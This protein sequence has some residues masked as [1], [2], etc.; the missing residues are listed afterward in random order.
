MIIGGGATGVE[1]AAELRE[2]SGVYASYG[3]EHLEALR[4]VHITLLEGAPRILA[5][6]AGTGVGRRAGAAGAARHPR[7]HRLQGDRD[8]AGQGAATPAATPIRPT[9]ACGRPASARPNSCPRWAC[10]PRATASSRSTAGCASRASSNIYALGD[11]AACVD[12]DGKPVPPRAQA[13]HQQADFLRQTF[14]LQAAGKPPAAAR[15]TPTPITVRW[16]RS[17]APLRWAA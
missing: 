2:A 14:L 11:C 17:A 16:C 10:R 15:P 1:L 9:C 8:R 7:G 4:D 3:F 5:P 12:R 6:L 13:A